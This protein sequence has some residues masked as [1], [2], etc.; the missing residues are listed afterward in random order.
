MKPALIMVD[1]LDPIDG[2][3]H[4]VS[5]SGGGTASNSSS[6]TALAIQTALDKTPTNKSSKESSRLDNNLVKENVI[7]SKEVAKKDDSNSKL[8]LLKENLLD[9]AKPSIF[10]QYRKLII[11]IVISAV[12]LYFVFRK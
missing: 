2:G 5:G 4:S 6:S 9:T 8:A 1:D 10:T 11:G 7:V 3:G 12:I